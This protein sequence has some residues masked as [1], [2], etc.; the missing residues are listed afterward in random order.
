MSWSRSA[1]SWT[2]ELVLALAC[3]GCSCSG[4]ELAITDESTRL[5]LDD[6]LPR[7]TSIFDGERV[8][9]RAARGE[10]VGFSVQFSDGHEHSVEA[11]VPDGVGR[12]T[13]FS[14]GFLQVREPSTS[15]YGQ[16]RGRGVYPDVLTP[17]S[18]PVRVRRSAYFDI[19]VRPEAPPGEHSGALWID[20]KSIQIELRVERVQ[21]ALEDYP[22][23]WVFYLPKEIARVHGVPEDDG[24]ELIALEARYH[25]LFREHGA[26]LATDLGP[27]RFPPRRRFVHDVRYWP[28]ALDISSDAAIRAD[29]RRWL[30]L[31]EGSKVIPFAVPVDEPRTLEA[32]RRAAHVARTIG[33]AGGGDPRLLRAVTARAEEIYDPHVDV[34]FSPW[35]IPARGPRVARGERFWTYNG[36]PP[37]AGSMIIDTGG[38]ALRTW[39]WIAYRYDIELWYAWEGLYFSDRY[40]R[41]GPTDVE[42]DP[43]TFDERSRGGED[44][45][46]G[47]GLLA[48]P[49]PRP[50]LRLKALR[51]GLS[52]RLLLGELERCG[53]SAEASAI[54]RRVV[55]R[56]LAEA[57]S[58]PSWPRDE[59]AWNAARERLFDAIARRC[60]GD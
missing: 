16:S 59:R 11:V 44:F 5:L 50:S 35:D 28:V 52:E 3:T 49:G 27:E 17:V 22:L 12:A 46:N 24:P 2:A 1:S 42:R 14:V 9:L 53:G 45:G 20:G 18:G 60:G 26:L 47:D 32:K 40:N 34:W 36:R 33:E 23:V 30:E 55:P 39:G 4:A 10:T 8:R 58:T 19:A 31:F 6:R 7:T 48:Y 37:S 29:V 51:R 54:A 57:G 56:A 25:R 38:E 41:G 15:M 13:G 43:I 21:I